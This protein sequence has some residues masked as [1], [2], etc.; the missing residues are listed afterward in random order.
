MYQDLELRRK[1]Y[2]GDM[3]HTDLADEPCSISRSLA[4][5][6][7]RWTLVVLKQAFAGTRRFD[8]FQR[9]LGI[10][11]SRLAERLDRLVEHGVLERAEYFDRRTRLEYRL[12]DKGHALYPVLMA[13]RSWGDAYLAPDGPPLTYQHVG[14]GGDVEVAVGCGACGAPLSARD[15]EVGA[16]PGFPPPSAT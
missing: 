11:R 12:T 4:L 6:G 14:C 15:V 1:C 3:R 5:L 16:G 8:D 10:A 2:G 13:L 7:D 9:S